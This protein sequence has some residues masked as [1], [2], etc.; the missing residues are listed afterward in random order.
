M[1]A[2]YTEP[3]IKF[4]HGAIFILALLLVTGITEFVAQPF[5]NAEASPH[6]SVTM[7]TSANR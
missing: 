2:D 5:G 7:Q 6:Y 1:N 3:S 4:S